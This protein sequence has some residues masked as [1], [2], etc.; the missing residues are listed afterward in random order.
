MKKNIGIEKKQK[1]EGETG[2]KNFGSDLLHDI[3][4]VLKKLNRLK[5]ENQSI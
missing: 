3:K 5:N 1:T 2:K 4:K